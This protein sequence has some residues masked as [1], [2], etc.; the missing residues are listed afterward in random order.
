MVILTSNTIQVTSSNEL[1]LKMKVPKNPQKKEKKV[2]GEII[3][4]W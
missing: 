2:Y 3:S 4:F 1:L